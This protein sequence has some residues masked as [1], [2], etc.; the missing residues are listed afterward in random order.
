MRALGA[1]R[2]R[3]CPGTGRCPATAGSADPTSHG[4]VTALETAD[5]Q[6]QLYRVEF[7]NHAVW[8]MYLPHPGVVLT[9]PQ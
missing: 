2:V 8:S 6:G 4:V 3:P 1:Q 5:R 7:D 9:P